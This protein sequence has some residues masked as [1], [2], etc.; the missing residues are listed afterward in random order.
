MRTI[1]G[2]LLIG[3]L[4]VAG[5]TFLKRHV[6]AQKA[7]FGPFRSGISFLLLGLILGPSVTSVFDEN[8]L[9]SMEFVAALGLGWI[10]FLFGM[11]LEW[12]LLRKVSTRLYVLAF[13]QALLTFVAVLFVLAALMVP[14][15]R[16]ALPATVGSA[17]I[18]WAGPVA[19]AACASDSAPGRAFWLA[20]RLR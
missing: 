8:T 17:V 6:P 5:A 11:H 10:G 20:S 2:I 3:F 4:A 16:A 7:G 9:A 1:L 19:L 13:G 12:R 18:L 14:S 15:G